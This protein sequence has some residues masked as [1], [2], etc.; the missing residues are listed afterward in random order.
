[1]VPR[2]IVSGTRIASVIASTNRIF[3]P[4]RM[5]GSDRGDGDRIGT[6]RVRTMAP[7]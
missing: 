7:R 4:R 3:S 2:I 1:M 5:S 6:V